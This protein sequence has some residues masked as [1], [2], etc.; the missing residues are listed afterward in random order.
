[1]SDVFDYLSAEPAIIQRLTRCVPELMEVRSEAEVATL[2]NGSLKDIAA[3]V[4]YGGDQLE[5]DDSNLLTE[6][7]QTWLVV[8]S[9]RQPNDRTGVRTRTVAGPLI[10][11]INKALI[12]YEIS[13]R[14][15]PLKRVTAPRPM[16][17][18][19]G[20]LFLPL[21]YETRVFETAGG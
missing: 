12:G 18:G 13:P 5:K 3:I 16:Q 19:G 10:T 2:D 17:K 20:Q 14:H 8:L 15:M 11:K 21:A 4:I 1:M 7:V 6:A 9:V